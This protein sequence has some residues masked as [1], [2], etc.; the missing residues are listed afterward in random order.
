MGERIIKIENLSHKFVEKGEEV[1]ALDGVTLEV[2]KGDLIFIT[3]PSGGGKTS[4][5]EAIS[6]LLIPDEGII[7][8]KGVDIYEMDESSR[9]KFLSKILHF[10]HQNTPLISFLRVYEHLSYHPA[11][12]RSGDINFLL[13]E[14]NLKEV[15][16]L[17]P[18]QLSGGQK[19]RLSIACAYTGSPE[20]VLLDE[21]FAEMDLKSAQKIDTFI[22]MKNEEGVTTIVTTHNTTLIQKQDK[23]LKMENGRVYL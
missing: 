22:R 23:V 16:N 7:R 6:G 17:F 21:P 12:M 18:H 5:L 2:F 9:R 11:C 10:S 13:E 8:I 15:K 14:L 1:I 20:I 4:L 3:G 19:K